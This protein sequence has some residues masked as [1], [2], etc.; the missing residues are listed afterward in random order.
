MIFN[1]LR[2]VFRFWITQIQLTGQHSEL[3]LMERYH[4]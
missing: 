4:D 2:R 1:P 3:R